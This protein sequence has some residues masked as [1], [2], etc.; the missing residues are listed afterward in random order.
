LKIYLVGGYVRDKLLGIEGSDRDYVVVGSSQ[1]EMFKQKFVKVGKGFPVYLHPETREEYTLA[2]K[3]KKIGKGYKG[4][5]FETRG[6]S[7]RDDLLRRDFTINAMALSKTGDLIDPF[8][9]EKD[10]KNKVFRHVSTAFTEDPLRVL[11]LARFK[12][13]FE[14]FTIAPETVELIH[15]IHESGELQSLTPE[16]I[17][18]EI[19]KSIKQGKIYVFFQT[20]KDLGVLHSIFPEISNF[21]KLKMI[22]PASPPQFALSFLPI[23]TTQKLRTSKKVLKFVELFKKKR[24][25]RSAEE[26]DEFFVSLKT[27]DDFELFLEFLELHDELNKD[28]FLNL[29]EKWK[30]LSKDFDFSKF[31]SGEEKNREFKKHRI[32]Q[33]QILVES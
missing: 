31:Q 20:L 6:V 33:F 1:R 15:K 21:E 10:L 3:D 14:D 19:S 9:G 25:F 7:L 17:F 12:S 4:F 23:E 24:S 18:L 27:C 30:Q 32:Q 2:R 16:R 28:Y 5:Y 8:G 22:P 29:F 13:R 26:L 11:R